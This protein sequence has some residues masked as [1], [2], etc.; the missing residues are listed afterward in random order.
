MRVPRRPF[1]EALTASGGFRG[2][3]APWKFLKYILCVLCCVCLQR[4]GR[5][6]P[7]LPQVGAP[8]CERSAPTKA[9]SI[10]TRKEKRA[11]KKQKAT[12]LNK[13]EMNSDP[14]FV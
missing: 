10:R 3:Q 6:G 11:A 7:P 12:S 1:S 4:A 8:G 9:G 5:A 2:H 14:W 13:S